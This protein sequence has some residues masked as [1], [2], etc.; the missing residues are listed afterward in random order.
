MLLF[1]PAANSLDLDAVR[2][3]GLSSSDD[4]GVRL[5]PSLTAAQKA[6]GTVVLVVDRTRL[7]DAPPTNEQTVRVRWVPPRAIKNLSP[8]RP[9]KAVTAAGGYVACPLPE[10]V[11]VLLIHRRG[12]WDVPKGKLDPGE[13][14][15]SCARREVREEVGIDDVRILQ[16]LG[17]TEHGYAEGDQYAVKTTHWYLMRT[18]AQSFEP[19]RVEGIRRVA[20]ARWSVARRHIGYETL[21]R[22]M[23][24]IESDVRTALSELEAGTGRPRPD[25]GG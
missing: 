17:T 9:P 11:A 24:R 8:Y 6:P 4:E 14:L 25:S 18:T 3:S 10:D 23:D 2:H 22:H 12:V 5:Y 15:M 1:Y 13:G 16:N 7:E 21:R 20:S 19:E